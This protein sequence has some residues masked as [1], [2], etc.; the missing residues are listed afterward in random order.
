MKTWPIICCLVALAVPSLGEDCTPRVMLLFDTSLA[1]DAALTH[2]EYDAAATWSGTFAGDQTYLIAATGWYSPYSFHRDWAH[3]PRALL[4]ESHHGKPG[5]Y[6]GNYLNWVFYHASAEQRATLPDRTRI[7][8]GHLIVDY[9]LRLLPELQYALM[10]FD[11][12]DGGRLLVPHDAGTA[13]LRSALLLQSTGTSAPF[14]E[15]AEDVLDHFASD[16]ASAPITEPCQPLVCVVLAG[17]LPTHDLDVSPRL[18]DADGDGD[19]PGTCSELG[20]PYPDTDDCSAYLDDVTW[21]MAHR[22]LRPDLDGTQAVTTHVVG[23]YLK[24]RLLAGAAA[25]GGGLYVDLGSGSPEAGLEGLAE[26]LRSPSDEVSSVSLPTPE[27][28]HIRSLWP[29][30]A[31]P[32]AT[33]AYELPAAGPARLTVHDLGGRLVR[34]LAEEAAPAGPGLA[35]WD[36]RDG[37][38]RVVGAGAYVV[39]LEVAGQAVTGRLTILR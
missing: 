6:R 28:P 23:L 15:A 7:Q 10:V 35:R 13:S 3:E 9:L 14:A 16:S 18:R 30:P 29:N 38:G 21:Y 8:A 27:R 26:A 32:G 33:I 36:G 39:K 22:D 37:A 24:H 11:G 17:G 12:D 25:N 4:V 31:N 5:R 1:M 20:A 2:P 34:V 19:G